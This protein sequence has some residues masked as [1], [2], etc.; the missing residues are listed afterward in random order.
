MNISARLHGILH[1]LHPRSLRPRRIECQMILAVSSLILL[2]LGCSHSDDPA[3]PFVPTRPRASSKP[4]SP[5]TREYYQSVRLL[6]A[7]ELKKKVRLGMKYVEVQDILGLPTAHSETA[8]K[9]S[10]TYSRTDGT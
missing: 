9:S 7:H 3:A 6:G 4:A 5:Y 10:L 1:S 2:P 8:T